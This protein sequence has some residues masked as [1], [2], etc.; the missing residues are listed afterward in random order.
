MSYVVLVSQ[1]ERPYTALKKDK[2]TPDEVRDTGGHKQYIY[3]KHPA[4]GQLSASPTTD[5]VDPFRPLDTTT[6]TSTPSHG[7][8]VPTPSPANGCTS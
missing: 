2:S 8:P 7:A 3:G 1:V 5:S 6:A 4:Q